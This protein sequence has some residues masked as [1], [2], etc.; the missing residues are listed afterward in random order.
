MVD[1]FEAEVRRL[2]AARFAGFAFTALVRAGAVRVAAGAVRVAAGAPAVDTRDECFVRCLT[3]FFA[4]ASATDV[5][6]NAVSSARSITRIE[7]RVIDILQTGTS[8]AE[9]VR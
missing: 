1:F 6:V 5:S 3:G 4:A 8:G 7:L 9:Q 2:A